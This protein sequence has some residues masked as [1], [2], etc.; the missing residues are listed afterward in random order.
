M[1]DLLVLRTAA[2]SYAGHDAWHLLA[3]PLLTAVYLEFTRNR[4]TFG[5]G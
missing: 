3:L 2:P 4:K 1:D 5:T